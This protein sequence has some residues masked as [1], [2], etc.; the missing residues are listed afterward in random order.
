MYT[1]AQRNWHR[2]REREERE[3]ASVLNCGIFCPVQHE[4][5]CFSLKSIMFHAELDRIYHGLKLQLLP[6]LP[7]TFPYANSF[8]R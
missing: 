1:T 4:T 5:R 8:E 2:E 7:F 6:F 3:G